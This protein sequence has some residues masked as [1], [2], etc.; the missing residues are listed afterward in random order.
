MTTYSDNNPEF[1][2]FEIDRLTKIPKN[3]YQYRLDLN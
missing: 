1:R 3:Y 2:V